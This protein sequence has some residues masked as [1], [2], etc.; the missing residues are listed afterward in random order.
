MR[1][2]FGP[3]PWRGRRSTRAAPQP[4]R[5]IRSP[6]RRGP[7]AL[8]GRC[9]PL[10]AEKVQPPPRAVDTPAAGAPR[11][12]LGGHVPGPPRSPRRFVEPGRPDSSRRS[13][14]G[15]EAP[16]A[17]LQVA[18]SASVRTDA[19]ALLELKTGGKAFPTGY[20]APRPI[21]QQLLID[22]QELVETSPRSARTREG[23]TG[24]IWHA[25]GGSDGEIRPIV[26]VLGLAEAGGGDI[27]KA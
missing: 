14:C 4:N 26:V 12:P 5:A 2:S 9:V 19:T 24:L 16:S 17:T 13:W 10:H 20:S 18:R 22:A 23:A 3:S 21:A 11:S 1:A 25:D 7:I 27:T 15:G 6:Q 8:L